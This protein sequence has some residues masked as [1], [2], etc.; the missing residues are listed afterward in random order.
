MPKIDIDQVPVDATTFY[1]EPFRQVVAGRERR[2]LG[3]AAG[4]AQFGVNLTRLKPDAASAL[5][6]WHQSEDEFVYVLEGELVLRENAGET[7]LKAGEAAA[8]KAGMA[9]GHC[10]INQTTRDAVYLE[11]GTRLAREHVEYPD[12]D[13][14][15]DRD[16]H[17]AHYRHK[18]GETY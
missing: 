15:L 14:M 3:E 11:I 13:L 6:H 16:E 8:F 9:D 7:L 4:L 1:P 12:V 18:S 17:G 10:L 5:R 2:R